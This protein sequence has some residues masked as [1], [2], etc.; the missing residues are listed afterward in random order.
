MKVLIVD[1]EEMI[2]NVLREYIEFEGNEAFE[3]ADG[4]QEGPL[5][6]RLFPDAG[7]P[8]HQIGVVHRLRKPCEAPARVGGRRFPRRANESGHFT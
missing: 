2:R 4:I 7:G 3:A 1:D 6:R 5:P 8:R